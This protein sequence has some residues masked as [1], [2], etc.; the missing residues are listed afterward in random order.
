[1]VEF[2]WDQRLSYWMMIV[3]KRGTYSFFPKENF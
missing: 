2:S 3:L 1:V